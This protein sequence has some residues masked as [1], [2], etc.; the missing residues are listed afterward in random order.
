MLKQFE[1]IQKNKMGKLHYLSNILRIFKLQNYLE[2]PLTKEHRSFLSKIRISAHSLNIETGR[3]N[4]T[5]REQHLCKFCPS[6][7]EDEKHLYYIALNTRISEIVTIHCSK[8]LELM[9]ILSE[10]FLTLRIYSKQ[11]KFANF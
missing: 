8:V 10:R 7:V 9:M 2:S 4:N 3:Y 1:N 5:P 11:N 6:S